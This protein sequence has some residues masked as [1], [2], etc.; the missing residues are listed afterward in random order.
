[1]ITAANEKI[2]SDYYISAVNFSD[3]RKISDFIQS[4]GKEDIKKMRSSPIIS[5]YLWLEDE[6][7]PNDFIFIQNAN[8]QVIFNRKKVS[9]SGSLFNLYCVVI[10]SA[11]HLINCS[12]DYILNIIKSELE[13]VF[14]KSITIRYSK[15]IKERKAT[16]LIT[17]MLR[18]HSIKSEIRNMFII[19]D[20]VNT[21]LPATIESAIY[22]SYKLIELF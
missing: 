12:K 22:S 2:K 9:N 4:A 7:F 10:S 17:P 15:I 14:K 21:G 3:M 6:L 5:I 16:L 13:L 19:G 11:N 20:W 18:R 8:I 1:L